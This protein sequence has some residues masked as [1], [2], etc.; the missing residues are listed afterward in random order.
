MKGQWWKR[1]RRRRWI[2]P[3][4]ILSLYCGPRTKWSHPK[5]V[6]LI[7]MYWSVSALR[8]GFLVPAG[9][10]YPYIPPPSWSFCPRHKRRLG[11]KLTRECHDLP[12]KTEITGMKDC[13]QSRLSNA[14]SLDSIAEPFYVVGPSQWDKTLSNPF[15]YS[16][17]SLSG[18][19]NMHW[20]SR[21]AIYIGCIAS[22]F[23]N[24]LVSRMNVINSLVMKRKRLYICQP[25]G[26]NG[27][28]L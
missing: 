4:V 6:T 9:R 10:A 11:W 19:M 27:R 8:L 5:K 23:S 12:L 21:Y 28:Y 15:T 18:W 2:A 1:Q 13:Q 7:M 25:T 17:N 26:R 14:Y 20:H 22:R 24:Y 16:L 3:L